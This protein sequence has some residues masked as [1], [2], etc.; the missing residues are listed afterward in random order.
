V[1][2]AIPIWVWALGA[3][4]N[5]DEKPLTATDIAV[6]INHDR[7]KLY[8]TLSDLVDCGLLE[9]KV[10]RRKKRASTGQLI[11]ARQVGYHVTR[12]GA[13][14]LERLESVTGMAVRGSKC[15]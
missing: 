7:S 3:C 13:E 8:G 10:I 5:I 9:K 15:R 2:G 11:R 1:S 6:L 4:A 12:A 14:R